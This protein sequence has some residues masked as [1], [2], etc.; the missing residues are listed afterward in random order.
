M[1]TTCANETEI[2]C[3][4]VAKWLSQGTKSLLGSLYTGSNSATMVNM[5]LVWELAVSQEGKSPK[6]IV[7]GPSEKLRM[8]LL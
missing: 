4:V 6:V 1:R 5:S 7:L 2:R 8:S 3:L